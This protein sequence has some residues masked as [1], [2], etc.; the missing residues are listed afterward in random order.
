MDTTSTD[1]AADNSTTSAAH[2]FLSRYEGFDSRK[3]SQ[4]TND[5]ERRLGSGRITAFGNDASKT[6]NME[7][8][9][10]EGDHSA[11][12]VTAT[13]T[14]SLDNVQPQQDLAHLIK[15]ST[16]LSALLSAHH[17]MCIQSALANA[18]RLERRRVERR[19]EERAAL[20]WEGERKRLGGGELFIASNALVTVQE[21]IP[22]A[23]VVTKGVLEQLSFH[24]EAIGQYLKTDRDR[25]AAVQL[26]TSIREGINKYIDSKSE[27]ES[28]ESLHQYSNGLSLLESIAMGNQS[29]RGAVVSVGADRND[30]VAAAW[31]MA[32]ACRFFSAQFR[33]HMMDVVREVQ[34]DGSYASSNDTNLTSVARDATAFA[35]IVLG[36]STNTD[37]WGR[38]FYCLRCGDL[39]AAK[40]ALASCRDVDAAVVDLVNLMAEM[41]GGEETIFHCDGRGN[42]GSF[43]GQRFTLLSPSSAVTKLRSVVG[44]LYEGVKTRFA[45]LSPSEQT[46]SS[47]QA[48]C[49]AMLS[50]SES[51]SEA[52]VLESSGLVKTVEDYLYASL[53]HALHLAE[54]A[55]SSNVGLKH[56][57][58]AIARLGSLVKEWG[59][60]YFEQE[61]DI[62]ETAVS[63][64]V[65]ASQGNVRD[66]IP[67]S[68]GWAYALPLLACQQY[69]SALAYLAQAGGCLGLMQAVHAAVV[70]DAAGIDMI[71]Y[72]LDLTDGP[73]DDE[74]RTLFPMLVSS[75]S[76]S[77]QGADIVSALKYL[78]LL[79][80]KG[81]VMN[82]QVNTKLDRAICILNFVTISP[83]IPIPN[84]KVRRLILETRQ[85]EVLAG[86]I[87]PDGS[88]SKAALDEYF[89]AKEISSS[90]TDAAG[91]AVR[92]GKSADGAELLVL[93]GRYSALFSLMNRELASHL[94]VN[95][96]EE[97][98]KRQ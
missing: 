97:F 73:K 62:P 9:K 1:N 79:S 39:V 92:V 24:S 37:V 54:D 41:Q 30:D 15:T 50:G 22:K 48:A 14:I 18:E 65:L 66:K 10:K 72:S 29:E 91:E 32:S 59:P 31:N 60:S 56:S 95:T 27:D 23:Q 49:L 8:E 85:F 3:L 43:G 13:T 16:S 2:S 90:L 19:D 12:A 57:C 17:E 44:D 89:S 51:I 98:N 28:V 96:E 78:I 67:T 46:M 11:V 36:Q 64:V 87:E 84:P 88:R 69:G 70:L 61:D 38:L 93:A 83:Y 52:S 45:S 5:L 80:G 58:Q 34:L 21:I 47:Y 81:K 40:S 63:A 4:R 68:G 26:L 75:F 77:L 6:T 25:E 82:T 35:E 94:A 20:D 55:S 53:W 76:A 42:S 86:K 7:E 33:G 71:D 74:N